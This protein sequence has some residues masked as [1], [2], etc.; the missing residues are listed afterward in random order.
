MEWFNGWI[1]QY[2]QGING[3]DALII[4]AYFI[5]IV[6]LGIRYGKS[7][8][9]QSYFLAGRSMTWWV[10]G[11]SLFASSI[12]SSTLIG[13]AGAAYCTGLAVFNYNLVSVAVMVFFAAFFLP[14]Y[15]KMG[16][17]TMPEFLGRRFDAKSRYYFSAITIFVNIF[18]DAAGSLY[19]AALVMKLVF[20]EANLLVL[21][22]I[23]AVLVAAYTIPGGLSAVVRVD[24][25]QGIILLVGSV[26]IT[27][28]A[29][30]NGGLEHIQQLMADPNSLMLS[31]VRPMNDPTVP[32]LG[33]IVG[34]PILGFFFWGNNQM[35]VQRCLTAKNVDEGRKGVL[36]VGVLTLFTLFVIHI[37]GIMAQ[38]IFPNLEKGDMVYPKLLIG[39]LPHAL[40]GFLLATLVAALTSALS[41]LLNA[42]ATLFTMD[43][44]VK[45]RPASTPKQLVWVGRVSSMIV[46]LIAI[47]WV[48]MIARFTSLVMYYQEMLSLVAPPIVATFILGVFWKRANATGAF[49]GLMGGLAL[50][51][52]AILFKIFGVGSLFGNLHFLLTVPIYF[53]VSA[54]IIVVVSLATKAPEPEKISGSTWTCENLKTELAEQ[55]SQP[56]LK[57]FLFWSIVLLV[58]CVAQL[59]W[60]W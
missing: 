55:R 29:A 21:S 16:I 24:M 50:G 27:V 41:G 15:I 1:S 20:P 12:S 11:L 4:I 26:I 34:I 32:W 39:M 10:I 52:A 31:L 45:A 49:A 37:P 59:I 60:F 57:S 46:L 14:F 17:Y 54:A 53:G 28:A 58:L 43:F 9:V 47:F 42:V 30:R 18:L 2:A 48:P 38:V 36:L 22:A 33:M 51:I 35:L 7:S 56:L 44:Y 13:Q 3:W 6:L 23:F 40:I 19:A 5:W 25:I 8:T